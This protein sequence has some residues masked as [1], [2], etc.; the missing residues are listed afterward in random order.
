MIFSD[1]INEAYEPREYP[2]LAYLADYWIE[3]RPFAGLKVLAAT[4][5]FRNTLVQYRALLAGGAELYVGRSLGSG[6]TAMPCDKAIVEFLKESGIPVVTDEDVRHGT[7]ADDFDLVLD[8]AGQFAFCHPRK[9]FVELTRSG[10][11]FFKDSQLPVYVADSGI[12]K[13]IETI[14]GTGDG[15][16]RGLEQLGFSAFEEKNLIVFGSGKVGC[17]IALQGVRRGMNVC[18]VTDTHNLN[19]A[20]NFTGV[21]TNNNVRI[22]DY[23]DDKIVSEIIEDGDYLVTATGVKNA[24][25]W[26]AVSALLSN[27]RIIAANMGVEDEFGEFVPK[28]RVLNQKAPLNFMLKEPTHLKYID[29]SLALHAALA[30]KLAEESRSFAQGTYPF[31]GPQDHPF[32]IEQRLLMTTIQNGAIG[33]EICDML[34]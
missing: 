25:S 1:A 19:T 22:E 2:A 4:P 11:Q 29:A 21:L 24:L 20:S 32:E 6:N 28:Q 16:F 13:R 26:P 30:A 33:S 8:C 27:E 18:V 23:Q 31:V 5:I 12:V 3:K 10:V 9:G 15:Y 17:G 14:L 34:R 7:V